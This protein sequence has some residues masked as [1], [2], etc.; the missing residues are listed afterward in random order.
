MKE[1]EKLKDKARKED[2]DLKSL[3]IYSQ[4]LRAQRKEKFE[5]TWLEKLEETHEV[6]KRSNGSYTFDSEFGIID[7]FPK[8]NKLLIR[9][10]N[11]WKKPGLRFIVNKIINKTA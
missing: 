9:D 10:K 2:N 8:A 7:F 1:S 3:G 11:Q 5:D 6:T 4:A